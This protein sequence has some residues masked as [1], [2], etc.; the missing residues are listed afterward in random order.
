MGTSSVRGS[1]IPPCKTRDDISLT[2]KR[3]LTSIAGVQ[4]QRLPDHDMAGSNTVA[5]DVGD[6]GEKKRASCPKLSEVFVQS[7]LTLAVRKRKRPAVTPYE[8]VGLPPP[9]SI[10]TPAEVCAPKTF[11]PLASIPS[12]VCRKVAPIPGVGAPGNFGNAMLGRSC[13][14]TMPLFQ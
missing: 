12:I 8:V 10:S 1:N 6:N 3:W 14:S 2:A 13:V 9:K 11:G 4:A 7:R 5:Y